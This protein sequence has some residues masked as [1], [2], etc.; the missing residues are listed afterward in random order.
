MQAGEDAQQE[1]DLL[2]SPVCAHVKE[3]VGLSIPRPE[4]NCVFAPFCQCTPPPSPPHPPKQVIVLI[5]VPS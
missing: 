4:T 5:R 3:G 1:N 2:T